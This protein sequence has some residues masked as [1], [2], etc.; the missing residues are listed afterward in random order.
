MLIKPALVARSKRQPLAWR[1]LA[2]GS[3]LCQAERNALAP[4]WAT[5][6][7]DYALQLGRLSEAISNGCRAREKVSVHPGDNARVRAQLNALPF[8]RRSV[9]VVIMAHVLEY[10]D[11]PH[12]L[13]READRSLAFD[14]YLVLTL[15]NPLALAT[16]TG[17]F[18]GSAGKPPWSGRYFSKARIEDWLGL[19]NYEVLA[20]G[21]AGSRAL[22][23]SRSDASPE[24]E[25]RLCN[26]VP[27]LRSCYFLIARKR[28]FPLTPSPGFLQFARQVTTPKT[29]PSP[30]SRNI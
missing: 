27:L 14:G 19:L 16:L 29:V 11:D 22:W 2:H 15:Y 23:P 3:Y 6:A 13:L 25:N 28:V 5:I 26:Y 30:T 7:G 12:Q 18:P 8:A 4:Y 21:Y 9:D 24:S 20:S 17:L 1:D 10:A